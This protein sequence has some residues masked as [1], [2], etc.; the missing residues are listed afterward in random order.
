[1]KSEDLSTVIPRNEGSEDRLLMDIAYGR[2][3]TLW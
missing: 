2:M 3:Q 1:M